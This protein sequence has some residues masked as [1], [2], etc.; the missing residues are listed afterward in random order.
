VTVPPNEHIVEPQPPLHP[1]ASS[2]IL[3]GAGVV[4]V[5]S[6][7]SALVGHRLVTYALSVVSGVLGK[8]GC[9]PSPA[10]IG[11]AFSFVRAMSSS[12]PSDVSQIRCV[13][14]KAQDHA[15]LS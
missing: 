1:Q 10:G 2:R 5:V 8:Y 14:R 3:V 7:T 13:T 4:G 11:A 12:N 6:T 9:Q 15:P